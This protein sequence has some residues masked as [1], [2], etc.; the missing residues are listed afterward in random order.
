MAAPAAPA[1]QA[2]SSIKSISLQYKCTSVNEQ[3]PCS[4]YIPLD[5]HDCLWNE[6]SFPSFHFSRRLRIS[7]S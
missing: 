4:N 5:V 6:E 3:Y 7:S 1:G 2:L